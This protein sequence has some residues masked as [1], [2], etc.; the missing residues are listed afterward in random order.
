MHSFYSPIFVGFTEKVFHVLSPGL[1]QGS[2]R[3]FCLI[4]HFAAL[5]LD[6]S[7]RGNDRW[8]VV[9]ALYELVNVVE[10]RGH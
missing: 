10:L 5:P 6:F 2:S 8:L 3:A 4:W 9:T 1:D 7:L